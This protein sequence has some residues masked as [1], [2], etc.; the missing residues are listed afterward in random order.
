MRVSTY[1]LQKTDLT[2]LGHRDRIKNKVLFLRELENRAQRTVFGTQ[3]AEVARH[4]RR[5]HNEE[6]HSL[7]TSP[8][9]ISVSISRRMRWDVAR[10]G[11]INAYII[12]VRRPGGRRPHEITKRKWEDN[13]K[14]V[15]R[16]T[17][18]EHVEWIHLA[19]KRDQ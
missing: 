4:W 11:E 18:W 14:M 8:N 6:L 9:I 7:H 16:E 15:L 2:A 13:I 12:S 5:M 10:M 17:E 3:E 1:H 19:Q